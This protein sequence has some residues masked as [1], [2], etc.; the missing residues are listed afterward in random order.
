MAIDHVAFCDAL[1]QSATLIVVGDGFLSLE[2]LAFGL[3]DHSQPIKQFRRGQRSGHVTL[4]RGE[5]AFCSILK[6]LKEAVAQLSLHGQ[7]KVD[8]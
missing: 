3:I 6:E 4:E 1:G 5:E 8:A 2:R 7:G